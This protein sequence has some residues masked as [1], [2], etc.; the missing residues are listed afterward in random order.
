MEFEAQ[1]RDFNQQTRGLEQSYASHRAVVT[2]LLVE[3]LREFAPAKLAILGSGNCHDLDPASLHSL[4]AAVELWDFDADALQYGL[5]R[6]QAANSDNVSTRQVD[7]RQ[8]IG[9][10]HRA[11]CD[12]V[13][14]ACVLSQL[15]SHLASDVA[16]S[17]AG[18]RSTDNPDV[19]ATRAVVLRATHL[20]TMLDLL[21]PGGVGL[22]VTDFVSSETLPELLTTTDAE[23]MAVAKS[24]IARQNFF[25]GCNPLAIF[26]QVRSAADQANPPQISLPWRWHIGEKAMAVI[27]IRFSKPEK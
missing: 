5:S 24:A 19:D 25:T 6:F 1:Q 2:Q 9:D 17:T 16:S 12:V 18:D 23:L 3:T 20:R 4:V 11:V 26:E 7:L 10:G 22:L 8:P 27:A 21:R 13:L 15:M 14:S